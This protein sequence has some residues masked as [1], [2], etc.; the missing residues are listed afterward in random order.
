MTGFR[1]LGCVLALLLATSGTGAQSA[2][3]CG[4][5]LVDNGAWRPGTEYVR[6]WSSCGC[7]T[8]QTISSARSLP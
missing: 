2:L 8:W 1:A 6:C 5:Y 7:T 4:T 3:R